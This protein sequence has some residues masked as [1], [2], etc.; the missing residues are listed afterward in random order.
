MRGRN[1][2]VEP[3][4]IKA[5]DGRR[6]VYICRRDGSCS[7]LDAKADAAEIRL[8]IDAAAKELRRGRIWIRNKYLELGL[9]ASR[10][11]HV[12]VGKPSLQLRSKE[13][14]Q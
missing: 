4:S 12:D 13:V 2:P 11:S 7:V 6:L 3:Y 8:L 1:A 14:A 10:R 5:G 9:G